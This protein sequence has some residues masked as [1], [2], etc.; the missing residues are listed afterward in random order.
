MPKF[1]I[2]N[3]KSQ[4]GHEGPGF[5]CILWVD[6]VK[7]AEVINQGDGGMCYWHWFNKEAEKTWVDHVA[8]QPELEDEFGGK[9]YK[10][11]Q[12]TVIAGLVDDYEIRK[13]LVRLC[14]TKTLY[15]LKKDDSVWEMRVRYAPEVGAKLRAKHGDN[16]H[17]IIN[18]TMKQEE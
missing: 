11:D 15:R 13:H 16:L 18:E 10:Q 12:D 14:K 17:E 5:Y 7:G 2:K 8:A 6:G 3:F 1:E 4:R 9:P